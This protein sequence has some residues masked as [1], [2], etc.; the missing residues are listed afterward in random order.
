MKPTSETYPP[1]FERYI[2]LVEQHSVL[3]ALE[4]NWKELKEFVSEIPAQKESYAY[5]PGKWTLKQVIHHLADTERIMTYRALRF[6]R[7]DPQQPLSFE[8]DLYAANSEL[9]DRDLKDIMN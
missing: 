6:A 4:E 5:A 2:P 9:Q 3:E 7:K 8:E 1:Y